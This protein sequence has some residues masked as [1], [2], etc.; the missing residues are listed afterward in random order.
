MAARPAYPARV[1]RDVVLAP[2][3]ERV[4]V[5]SFHVYSA[6]EI[7]RR[8]PHESHEVARCA[9]ARMI[10]SLVWQ[11]VSCGKPVAHHHKRPGGPFPLDLVARQSIGPRSNL[12]WV[13]QSTHVLTWIGFGHGTYTLRTTG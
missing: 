7:G 2:I 8:L 5:E 11:R 12:P 6:R 13:S 4:L 9:L 1:R 10:K 3:I